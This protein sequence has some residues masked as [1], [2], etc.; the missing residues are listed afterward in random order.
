[1]ARKDADRR[2]GG[3]ARQAP[4]LRTSRAWKRP[5]RRY[6]TILLGSYL[7][8]ASCLAGFT[9]VSLH[10]RSEPIAFASSRAAAPS[11]ATFLVLMVL[12]GA[13]PDY[14]GLTKLPHLDKLRARGTLFSNAFDGILESE[15]PTGH[16]TLS[17][18]SPPSANGILGFDWAQNDARYSLFNPKVVRSGAM[19]HIMQNAHVPTIAGLFKARHPKERVVALSGHKY[20]AADPLGGPSA[21]AI[22]YYA[23]GSGGRYVPQAIPGHVPPASVMDGKNVIG[24]TTHLGDGGEDSLATNLAIAAFKRMHAHVIMINYPEFDWPLGHVYGGNLDRKDAVKMMQNFDSDLGKIEDAYRSAGVL[25]KTLFVVTA[26][27]G[28]GPIKRFI[29]STVISNAVAQAGT[30]APDVG[31]NTAAYVWLA[32]HAKALQ[33]AKNV[34][35]ARDP[36]VQSAYY[37]SPTPK[38]HYILAGGRF[39]NGNVNAANSY[40]ANTLLNGHQPDVVVMAKAGATFSSPGAHWKADHGGASWESQHIPLLIAGPGVKQGAVIG[41]GAQ[42]EDI[43]PTALALMG[44][45]PTRMQGKVLA[46]AMTSPAG[47]QQSARK[48]EI[49]RMGPLISALAAQD[50]YEMSH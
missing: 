7:A 29:P 19:E 30:T 21:D 18:G 35:A 15:T 44:V 50:S 46:D 42:L 37:L 41:Q 25:G 16:T 39:V 24:P 1:M 43:A 6:T 33:V 34:L 23:P 13:R 48:G 22:M 40:L 32:D 14:F 5:S 3:D 26:D 38:P 8:F 11:Q 2:T 4:P 27:H 12:D 20:Y 17:T 49:A 10:N 45:S 31:N 36:G 9:G 47:R 28:M